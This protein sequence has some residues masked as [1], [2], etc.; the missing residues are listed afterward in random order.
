MSAPTGYGLVWSDEFSTMSISSS[1]YD[2]TKNWWSQL[3]MGGW[4]GS[5]KFHAPD[6]ATKP[7]SIEQKGGE[8]ALRITMDRNASGELESGMIS[9]TYPDG[10]HNQKSDGDAYGYYEVRMWLPDPE[11]GIW[12]SFWGFESERIVE[13]STRDHVWEMDIVEH[14]GSGMP[15]RYTTNI[16]DWNWSGETQTGHSQTYYRNVVGNGVLNTGWHTYG[17]EIT[18]ETTNFYYDDKIYHSIATPSTLDTNMIWMI[19]LAAGGAWPVDPQLNNVDMW[20][21]Y[22]RYYEKGAAS[23]PV[24]M[25]PK[26][27]ITP[28]PTT[29]GL[30][31]ITVKIAGTAYKGDPTF[32]IEVDDRVLAADVAVTADYGTDWQTFT[33]KGDF[34]PGGSQKH[35]IEIDLLN[36]LMKKGVGDRNLYVDEIAFNGVVQSQ[37]VAIT[38]SIDKDWFFTL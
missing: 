25:P 5:A 8:T 34:D 9:S 11:K 30:D 3:P 19:S 31:T 38:N 23:A 7:F 16:H 14:Y 37:N 6:S 26:E 2:T 29:P 4:F 22:F 18:K 13:T 24:P 15:D 17:V 33:F 35:K 1:R 28:K 20:V 10:S 12:P 21:D 32:S 27:E 36:D